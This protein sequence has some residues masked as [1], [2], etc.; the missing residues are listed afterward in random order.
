MTTLISATKETSKESALCIVSVFARKKNEMYFLKRI[1][2]DTTH[3][4]LL[5]VSVSFLC[6]N[7]ST[8]IVFKSFRP[9]IF[10]LP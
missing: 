4:V 8:V 2:H 5:S 10:F 7:R 1:G 6:L 3:F 9:C